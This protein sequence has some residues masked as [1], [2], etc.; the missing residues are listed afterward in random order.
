MT[1]NDTEKRCY[2]LEDLERFPSGENLHVQPQIIPHEL[3]FSKI[4]SF[5]D[6]QEL[7]IPESMQAC[8]LHDQKPSEERL[9]NKWIQRPNTKNNICMYHCYK[10]S[11]FRFCLAH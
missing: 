10:C 9:T 8:L 3:P 5:I 1:S 7:D 2:L 4:K 11:V 6:W